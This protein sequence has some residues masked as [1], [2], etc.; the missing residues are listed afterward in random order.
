[1]AGIPPLL[2]VA[3]RFAVVAAFV[4]IVPRPVASWRTVVGVGFS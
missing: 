1:M 3:I 4:V 2:F